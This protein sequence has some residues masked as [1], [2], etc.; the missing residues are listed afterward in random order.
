M[1]QPLHHQGPGAGTATA[2]AAAGS[3][4]SSPPLAAD[5]IA[6]TSPADQ[7]TVRSST[8]DVT[9]TVSPNDATVTAVLVDGAGHQFFPIPAQV[10]AS[11]GTWTLHFRGI[12]DGNGYLL[13]ASIVGQSVSATITINV[14]ALI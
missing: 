8:F 7:S 4:P 11:G 6:I 5:T 10:Q 9:G 13:T 12:P 3:S 14:S 1:T 2:K